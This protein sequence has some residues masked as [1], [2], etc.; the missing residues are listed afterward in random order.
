MHPLTEFTVEQA[1]L[2]WLESLGW[3]AKH[4]P[5]IA[6]DTP[7]AERHD[8]GQVVLEDCLWQALDNLN[9]DVPSEAPEEAFRKLTCTP[10]RPFPAATASSTT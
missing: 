2:T 8:Y 10:N 6:P 7:G 5:G 1:T 3:A 9:P 4:G